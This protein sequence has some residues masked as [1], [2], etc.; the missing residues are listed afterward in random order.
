M[1]AIL[2]IERRSFLAGF[3]VLTFVAAS[4]PAAEKS[5]EVKQSE[6]SPIGK[7][8]L[9][10][11]ILKLPG[12]AF[13]GTPKNIETNT[14]T[15][16]YDPDKIRPALMVPHGLKNLARNAKATSSDKGISDSLLV[17]V[18][19]GDKEP[20]EQ[21]IIFLRKGVQWV[22]FDLGAEPS[23]LFVIVIWHAHNVPKVYHSVVVQ[24]SNDGDFL[25]GVH[26]LFNNDQENKCGLGAGTDREYFESFQ[27]KL[28]DAKGTRA[29]FVRC[30]SQGSTESK[31]NE[32]TEVEIYGR[33]AR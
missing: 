3:I 18:N 7:D 16:P 29:R 1:E 10:P 20:S 22:Q 12:A 31:L 27:G 25:K 5:A 8:S 4:L 2:T 9:E 6:P 19:D 14:Y 32:Y 15:E 24:A 21:S 13:K 26:T 17:K 23:D 30:Y 33:P 11:L 28:I